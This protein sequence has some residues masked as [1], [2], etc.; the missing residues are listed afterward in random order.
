MTYLKDHLEKKISPSQRVPIRGDQV[1]NSAGGFVWEVTPFSQ[2]RRWL[3]LGSQ[4]GSY[5]ASEKSLTKQN[6]DVLEKC[7]KLDGKQ[8]VAEIVAISVEGR[9][10][11][12][13]QAVLA[14]AFCIAKGD[15]DTKQF[16]LAN[17]NKVCRIGTHLFQ[18]VDFLDS[19]GNL[20]GRAKR[21]TLSNWY[22]EKSPEDVAYQ[23]IKYRQR[24]GWSHRDVLRLAHPK[25]DGEHAEIFD[26]I[27]HGN[28]PESESVIHGFVAAQASTSVDEIVGAIN[29][30]KIPREAI[31]TE[32]LKEQ[33]V[34]QALLDSGMGL[35]ALI[36]N[37][38]N[39]TRIGLLTATSDATKEVVRRLK[40]DEDIKKSRIH[41]LNVLFALKT[42]QSGGGYRS[43]K[44]W[45]PVTRIVDALDGAFYKS[46]GNV[47]ATG[48]SVL[49]AL[50]V[51]GSMSQQIGDTSLSCMEAA[52]A[53]CMVNQ[54]VEDDVSVFGFDTRFRALD[55]SSRRRIDDNMRALPRNFGGTD[56]ALPMVYAKEKGL[57][58]DLFVVYTDNETWAGS[59]HPAKALQDYRKA[60]GIDARLAVIGMVSNGFSIADPK[61]AGMIDL[62]GFD[63]ATPNLITDFALGRL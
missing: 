56:C 29:T 5:Y 38:A 11:K 23:A 2:L 9:A 1:K 42:Y 26:W 43:D 13:D 28:V 63:T 54:A 22:L 59:V 4:G 14:L 60:T 51:S 41:P 16:A 46:F 7:I 6:F 17:V 34:W 27:A 58:V 3:V 45:T 40:S 48:Q 44:S 18:L 49:L 19:F 21:R 47:E 8:T 20:T 53:M 35:T 25:A 15:E 10:A 61:D 12:N 31:P 32:F 57:K 33:E 50:D 30:W 39:M 36:R 55:I 52:V 37:L 62:V 24:G